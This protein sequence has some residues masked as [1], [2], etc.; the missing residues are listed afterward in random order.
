MSDICAM[1]RANGDWFAYDDRGRF[2]VPIFHSSGDAMIARLRNSEMLLFKPVVLDTRLLRQFVPA[3]GG[4]DVDFRMVNDPLVNLNRGS[5]VG[6]A[7]VA[8]LVAR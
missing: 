5:L 4:G 6:H 7:Q 8:S 3:S 1:R 2:L